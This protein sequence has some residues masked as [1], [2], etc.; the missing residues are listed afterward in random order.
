MCVLGVLCVSR[1]PRPSPEPRHKLFL[2]CGDPVDEDDPY[3]SLTNGY[4]N[5]DYD[6]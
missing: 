4:Y 1:Y 6:I 5:D 2:F 3:G